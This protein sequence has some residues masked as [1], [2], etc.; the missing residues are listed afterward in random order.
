MPSFAMRD[1]KRRGLDAQDLGRTTGT[2]DSPTGILKNAKDLFP[3]AFIQ[4][5]LRCAD[6]PSREWAFPPAESRPS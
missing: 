4:S 3:H 6:C 1:S 2:S 5:H